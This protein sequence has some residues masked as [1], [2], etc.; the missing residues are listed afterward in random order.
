MAVSRR[1]YHT[2]KSHPYRGLVVRPILDISRSSHMNPSSVPPTSRYQPPP[3]PA[4][5]PG[6]T[7]SKGGPALRHSKSWLGLV[8]WIQENTFTPEWLP[9]SLRRPLFGYVA[10]V[11]IQAAAVG[12][13]LLALVWLPSWGCYT[14]LAV[15]GVAIVALGWGAGPSFFASLVGTLLVWFVV[16]PV[17]FSWT[18]SSTTDGIALFLYM[19]V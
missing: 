15:L 17:R 12:L 14:I 16:V 10:A 19:A 8:R 11:L 9:G 13:T 5:I 3:L 6:E 4:A 1:C 7:D 2:L 18:L